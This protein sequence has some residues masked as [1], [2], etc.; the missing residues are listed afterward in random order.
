ME[1]PI[2]PYLVATLLTCELAYLLTCLPNKHL[3]HLLFHAA[4]NPSPMQ[5]AG[6]ELGS[7]RWVALPRTTTRRVAW[8]GRWSC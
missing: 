7:G 2:H 4:T 8:V 3:L 5:R 6:I 1:R